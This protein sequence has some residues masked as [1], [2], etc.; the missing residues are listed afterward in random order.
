MS[1]SNNSADFDVVI[2]GCSPGGTTLAAYLARAGLSVLTL[3]KEP[4]PR[5]HVGES[6]T[7]MAATV[8][9]DFALEAEMERYQFPLKGG[10]KVIGRDAKNEFFVPV[11]VPTW[12]VRRNEFDQLLLDNALQHGVTHRYGTVHDLL[13]DG[14]R[15]AGVRYLCHDTATTTMRQ[16]TCRIVADASGRAAVLSRLGVAGPLVYGDEFR[17]QTAIFTQLRQAR[18]DPG[19][20]G[21]NTFLFYAAVHHWAWF[22]PLSS[23]V[24]SVGIVLP[25]HKVRECGGAA[26]ALQWGLTQLNPDLSW[27][28]QGCEHVEQIRAIAN[29]SYTVEPFVGN[30]WLCVGDAHRFTDPIFSFGVSFAMLEARAASQAILQALENGECRTPFAAYAAHCNRGQNAA[31]DVI[32]YF[33]QF[34]VFFGYQSRGELR[35]DLIQLL[36][37]D[38]YQADEMRALQVMRRALQKFAHPAPAR[39][40]QFPE[41]GP[42]SQPVAV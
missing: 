23:D 9:Q 38:L 31:A 20:M 8:L 27:R 14:D 34:P 32:R 6:L 16:V 12:Q 19:A 5:Y 42:V 35:K 21:N 29:Y 13:W 22:I 26:A 17:R 4:F 24:T 33:W 37:G 25:G 39:V 18:R 11:L 2:I 40:P 30:G 3:E 15:V 41:P 10:V 7:G 36:A 1:W 28:V